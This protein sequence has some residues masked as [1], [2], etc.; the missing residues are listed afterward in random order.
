[1]ADARR[2][3]GGPGLG[4]PRGGVR[5]RAAAV[6]TV[7][8]VS[9]CASAPPE[10]LLHGDPRTWVTRL[11]DM[12]EPGFV[13]VRAPHE[14]SVDELAGGEGPAAAELRRHGLVAAAEAEYFRPVPRLATANG[15]I[16][17][18]AEAERFADLAGAAAAYEAA[19]RRHDGELGAEPLSTGPLGDAAHGDALPVA[20]PGGVA[21]VQETVTVRRAN[22]VATVV[23]RGRLGGVGLEDALHLARLMVERET[24]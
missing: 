1:M 16:S 19:V 20:G 11:D 9:A 14:A 6:L 4:E 2:T 22:A 18:I 15:P 7:A 24:S 5:I 10:G 12:S 17:V 21:L 8:A 13:V 3:R 23:V